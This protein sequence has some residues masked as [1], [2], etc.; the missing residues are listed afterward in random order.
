MKGTQTAKRES[1]GHKEKERE[2]GGGARDRE[3]GIERE[4]RVGERERKGG[5]KCRRTWEAIS[6]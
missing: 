1:G 3:G 6:V 5:Y 2:R 4:E